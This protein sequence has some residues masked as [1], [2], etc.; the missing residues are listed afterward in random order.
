METG[1]L[2]RYFADKKE[3]IRGLKVLPR[4]AD[5][6]LTKDF[7]SCIIGPRRSGKS[8]C[9]YDL[10]LN[11]L[12]LKDE[13]FLYVNFEDAEM[14]GASFSEILIAVN[15]H[16]E[17]YGKKPLYLFLDEVQVVEGWHKALNSLYESKRHFIVVSG[18]SSKL[19]SKEIATSL[20][21]RALSYTLL[22]LSFREYMKFGG[23]SLD[24]KTS[25]EENMAK[26]ILREYLKHG[27]FPAVALNKE[28]AE[29]FFREYMDL[30]VFRDVI[31]RKKIKNIF[32]IKAIVR[33][34]MSSFSKESSIHRMFDT[35]K[36]QGIK[37]SKKTVYNYA[38][39]LEDAF[40]AFFLRKFD[41]SIKNEILSM[42]K[43]YICDNGLVT[44]AEGSAEN[45]GRLAENA[46]FLE[47]KRRQNNTAEEIAYYKLSAGNEVDFAI[48]KG[49]TAIKLIQVTAVSNL[50][51]INKRE[52]KALLEASGS[53][54]CSSLLVITWDYEDKKM[55]ESKEINFVPLW[56]WLLESPGF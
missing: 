54:K 4:E 8:Y 27:G 37:I 55:I 44:S 21:G 1:K 34:L 3:I 36:S 49:K 47:L 32:V 42:P 43:C 24:I 22:P 15:S 41:Y 45:F 51:D 35:L 7:I 12:K 39:Y 31:E 50:E 5:I 40:F 2:M 46:V 6:R 20:R 23:V 38:S 16:E 56:K 30:V 33:L 48:K 13:D 19:L 17:K 9:M 52:L 14:S 11:K 29:Q 18:S 28:I 10:V 26:N 25:S 53:L